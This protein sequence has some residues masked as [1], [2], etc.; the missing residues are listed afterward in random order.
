MLVLVA[1]ACGGEAPAAADD[2]ADDTEDTTA[3]SDEDSEEFTF[4]DP[5]EGEF[6]RGEATLT[7]GDQVYTFDN[8]YCRRGIENTQNDSVPFS[9]G[10]FGEVDGN[11]A[12][13]DASVHDSSGE[14]RMEGDGVS[15][16]VTFNDVDDFE[17]P[18]VDWS[19]G[20][21]LGGDV[22]LEF[23]GNTVFVET[24][25]DNGLTDDFEEI[26]GTLEATCGE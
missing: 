14:D 15:S 17:N 7:V 8:Y 9:S 11:R 26:P 1:A 10:A 13:L 12:Q 5:P 22:V 2:P 3:E 21:P 25:F 20:G 4:D 18:V 16:N 24:T 23:D 19:S 6:S